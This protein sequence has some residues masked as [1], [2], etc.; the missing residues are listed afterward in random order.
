MRLAR[1]VM[2]TALAAAAAGSGAP[3]TQPVK[4][5]EQRV[6]GLEGRLGFL[7]DDY[8]TTHPTSTVFEIGSKNFL[9]VRTEYG[10]FPVLINS[11]Q[12]YG[13]GVRVELTIGN[14]YCA[15]F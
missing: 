9:P 10:A 4:T 6:E 13:D 5:I 1:E 11:V 7:E 2:I 8:A 3:Q 14:P 12:S 15:N